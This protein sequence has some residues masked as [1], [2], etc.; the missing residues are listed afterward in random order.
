MPNRRSFGAATY[1]PTATADAT[2]L[3]NSTF[4]AIGAGNSAS[5]GLSVVEI[6]MGG[7]ATAS[8]VNIM[9]FAREKIVGATPG[10]L[11]APNSDGPLDTRT[12]ALG[13]PALTFVAA[14]TPPQRADITTSARLHLTFNAFGGI[15]RWMADQGGAWGITGN[16]VNV[17]ESVLSAYTGGSVGAIGS[18][19]IYEPV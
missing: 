10:A 12:G 8:A 9:Q 15:V 1:T 5:L 18:H 17:S 19:I 14:T 11:A 6:Y 4:Q 3:T 7:Q 16:A 13:T 2:T